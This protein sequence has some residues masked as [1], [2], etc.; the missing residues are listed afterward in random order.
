[1]DTA[2]LEVIAMNSPRLSQLRLRGLQSEAADFAAISRM[3]NLVRLDLEDCKINAETVAALSR[4]PRL[5]WIEFT[6]GEFVGMGPRTLPQFP[7]LDSL[8]FR[9][10]VIRK[11]VVGWFATSFPQLK[12]FRAHESVLDPSDWSELRRMTS[13]HTFEGFKSSIPDEALQYLP[14]TLGEINLF[15]SSISGSGFQKLHDVLP[16]LGYLNLDTTQATDENLIHILKLTPNLRTL[17]IP[18]T[19]VGPAGFRQ[20]AQLTELEVLAMHGVSEPVECLRELQNGVPKLTRIFCMFPPD[21]VA[22][23]QKTHPNCKLQ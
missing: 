20:I 6:R 14:T 21:A 22:A 3:Q 16:N 12:R 23:F 9:N 1:M 7:A 11:G 18:N 19:R 4:I 10:A 13:L 2:S 15:G 5:G 17:S 8:C